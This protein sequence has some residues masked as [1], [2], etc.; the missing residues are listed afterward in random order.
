MLKE[1]AHI[2]AI[3]VVKISGRL[4]RVQLIAE[5]RYGGWDGRNLA[6][7]RTVR[8]RSARKL[9]RVLQCQGD[10]QCTA[11]PVRGSQFCPAHNTLPTE[12][13]Q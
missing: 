12:E 13:G 5:S 3:Y 11:M 4:T 10:S 6:T 2:G 7:G 8:I 9:R 1:A